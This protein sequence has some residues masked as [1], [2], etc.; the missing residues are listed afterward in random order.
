MGLTNNLKNTR[1]KEKIVKRKNNF[2]ESEA[3]MELKTEKVE[4]MCGGEAPALR[5]S[6]LSTGV[7]LIFLN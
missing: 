3:A 2:S 7:L 1:M 5:R 4:N 6:P